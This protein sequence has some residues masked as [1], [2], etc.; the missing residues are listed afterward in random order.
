MLTEMAPKKAVADLRPGRSAD[1]AALDLPA[2][3][4]GVMTSAAVS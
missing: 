4:G 3:A 1:L 2:M